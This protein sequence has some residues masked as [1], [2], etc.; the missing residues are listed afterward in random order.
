[1]RYGHACQ[2]R[3]SAKARERD[4]SPLWRF[5]NAQKN[6]EI[7]FVPV[8]RSNCGLPKSSATSSIEFIH[9]PHEKPMLVS[10]CI[11][12]TG[13]KRKMNGQEPAGCVKDGCAFSDRLGSI[14]NLSRVS[15]IHA[16]AVL[17][18]RAPACSPQPLEELLRRH[19]GKK[20]FRTK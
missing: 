17:H 6:A 12:C 16:S 1:V 11:G 9:Q 13:L 5:G 4:H 18:L 2:S 7:N 14:Q 10:H 8:G 19:Q 20:Y 3:P 15:Q